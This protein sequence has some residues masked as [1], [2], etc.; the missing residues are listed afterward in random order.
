[1]TASTSGVRGSV[2]LTGA[3]T[4]IGRATARYLAERRLRVFAGVRRDEDA[5]S[6]RAEGLAELVPIRLDV[7]R[8]EEI[9][10]ARAEIASALAAMGEAGLAGVVNN[11][12][13]ALPAVQEFIEV[14]DFR[15]Q[16]EVNL[17]AVVAVNRAFFSLVRAAR[18]RIVNIGSLG[19]YNAA[20]FLG[21]YAASKFA[22]EGLTD[23]LR[24]ELRPFGLEVALVEPG[25]IATPIWEKSLGYGEELK[26]KLP[27]EALP[28]Y[29][30]LLEKIEN[31]ARNAARRGIPA[32]RVARAIHHALT[33]ARPRTRYRVGLDANLMRVLTRVLPDRAMDAIVS[34]FVGIPGPGSPA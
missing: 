32:E 8:A 20:P 23:S 26:R 1:M 31:Y 15:R 7:T 18:G 12:G 25:S 22:L 3:S 9:A 2:L 14:D 13:L 24:R 10:A 16:I 17:I 30:P 33:A 5:A 21:P 28:L 27:A 4:G 11:A 29:A 34:R 19:G 6:L